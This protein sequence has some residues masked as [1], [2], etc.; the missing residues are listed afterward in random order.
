[1]IKLVASISIAIMPKTIE[2]VPVITCVKYKMMISAANPILII[3]SVFP[4]FF[5]MVLIFVEFTP[6]YLMDGI[7]IVSSNAVIS[8]QLS[9]ISNKSC[10]L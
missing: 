4:I 10:K 3:R 6:F 2:M 5:F 7:T 1:M 8:T 9:A